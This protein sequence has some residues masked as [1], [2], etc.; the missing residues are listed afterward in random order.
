MIA[1]KADGRLKPEEPVALS[2]VEPSPLGL[3]GA[4]D[5]KAVWPWDVVRLEVVTRHDQ[6]SSGSDFRV[7]QTPRPPAA[8][9]NTM[10]VSKYVKLK[11]WTRATTDKAE[12]DSPR[13]AARNQE[14]REG[15]TV[16]PY[17]V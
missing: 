6:Y 5:L 3:A 7:I 16:S 10:P 4:V 11:A 13:R 17:V 15:E 1:A 9:I 14:T 8:R 2:V 12:R